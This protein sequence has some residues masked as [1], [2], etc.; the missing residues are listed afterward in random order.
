MLRSSLRAAAL[1]ALVGAAAATP[2]E[3]QFARTG[4]STVACT[5][6]AV[7][8]NAAVANALCDANW[9]VRWFDL[10]GGVSGVNGVLT[11]AAIVTAPPSPPWTP[12]IPG[13]Q[14]WI[15]VR[16]NATISPNTSNN[17]SN[18]RYFF[19]T[20]FT[21][22][23]S[24]LSFGIGWDNRLVGAFLSE[25]PLAI[26]GTGAYDLTGA[27][28]V[29]ALLGS[30]LAQGTGAG[31]ALFDGRS[32]FCRN[33]DGVFPG[34]A[35]PGGCVVDVNLAGLPTSGPTRTLTFVIEGDGSTDGFLAGSTNVVPEPSTY[36]MLGAGLV[37]LVAAVRRRRPEARTQ[38]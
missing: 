28:G 23:A 15:G 16:P 7:G 18:Y 27:S 34:S 10:A 14:Q 6:P 29:T 17:A 3:A 9:G 26:G 5:L 11:N 31:T 38:G 33:G 2:A 35:F 21:P 25:A 37:G 20:T 4:A 36:A 30:A 8:S 19:S 13:V 22:G 24:S 1:L 12:N 32:G